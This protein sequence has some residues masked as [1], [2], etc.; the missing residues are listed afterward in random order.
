[1]VV[2]PAFGATDDML[3]MFTATNSVPALGA[4]L[5]LHVEFDSHVRTFGSG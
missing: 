4:M 3:T 1:L 5:S 2:K